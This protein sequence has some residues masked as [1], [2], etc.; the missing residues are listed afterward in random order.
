MRETIVQQF[1]CS[2]V[3]FCFYNQQK[4]QLSVGFTMQEPIFCSQKW[5]LCDFS[6]RSWLIYNINFV[7]VR[8]RWCK[9]RFI[10]QMAIHTHSL[11]LLFGYALLIHI[12]ILCS[13]R[14]PIIMET[15]LSLIL[16]YSRILSNQ[17]ILK[18][19]KRV[20]F[21]AKRRKKAQIKD[22]PMLL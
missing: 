9:W 7:P 4:Q 22:K 5:F 15:Q 19:K 6:L 21:F 3:A 12:Y 8:K 11:P 2:L 16:Q 1:K 17:L 14:Y 13:M 20:K 10:K 18:L